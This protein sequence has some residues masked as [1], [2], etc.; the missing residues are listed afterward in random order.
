MSHHRATR[1][2]QRPR[3]KGVRGSSDLTVALLL[4][5]AG[6]AMVGMTAP[7][8]FKSSDTAARTFDRQ[9]QILER[10]AGGGSGGGAQGFAAGGAPA[11]EVGTIAAPG[12]RN[13]AIVGGPAPVRNAAELASP[14]PAAPVTNPSTISSP[15]PP[16]S[17]ARP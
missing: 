17:T 15:A 7:T 16:L 13:L 1:P 2:T 9:V 3:R 6:A 14:A 5:A 8:L 12:T 10:G 4:T 11:F